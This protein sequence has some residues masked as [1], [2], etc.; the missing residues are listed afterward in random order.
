VQANVSDLI[1]IGGDAANPQARETI[2]RFPKEA[3]IRMERGLFHLQM[4]SNL[5]CP[6][7][8]QCR[9]SAAFRISVKGGGWQFP[10]FLHGLI[11]GCSRFPRVRQKTRLTPPLELELAKKRLTEL[12]D[13]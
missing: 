7:L 10:R 13:A 6:T 3:R 8:D 1:Q 12:I 9:S 5:G 11:A 4:G 2:R